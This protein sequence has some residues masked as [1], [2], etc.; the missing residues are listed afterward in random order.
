MGKSFVCAVLAVF[1]SLFVFLFYISS[2]DAASKD[3]QYMPIAQQ[4]LAH[5]TFEGKEGYGDGIVWYGSR[6]KKVVALTFD[7][8]MTPD[9]AAHLTSGEVATYNDT[10]ITDYLVQEQVPAT[11]FMSGMWIELYPEEAK[12]LAANPLF[13]IGNHTYSHPSLSG[14][15][16]G[17][18]QIPEEQ[19]QFEVA[20]VQEI[21]AQVMQVRPK[22]FRFPGGCYDQKVLGMVAKEG[23]VTVHWDVISHDGFNHSQEEIIHN[24]LSETQ[25]GSIIVMH[26]GGE[27]NT[28]ETANALPDIVAGLRARGFQFVT[29]DELLHPEKEISIDLFRQYLSQRPSFDILAERVE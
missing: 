3:D 23:L 14:E 1:F 27:P 9:M 6:D 2:A 21:A 13:E 22:Y 12:K 18:A 19:Y 8:D 26:L 5:G 17:L 20:K 24:V 25:N 10:R 4:L 15:C 7:A 11:I 28:P 16:Y 29:V